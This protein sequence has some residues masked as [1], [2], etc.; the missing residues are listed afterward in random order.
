MG[1][2]AI[3]DLTFAGVSATAKLVLEAD[4]IIL[5]G[6]VRARIARTAIHDYGVEGDDLVVATDQCELRARL[7]AKQANL[8][9]KAIAKP[10]PSLA[11]NLGISDGVPTLVIGR[12]TDAALIAAVGMAAENLGDTSRAVQILTEIS[13]DTHLAATMAA[14]RSNP[15]AALWCITVKGPA[16]PLSEAK[17]R[18][19]LR[20]LGYIDTKS[21][22]VSHRMTATRYSKRRP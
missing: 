9:A 1:R 13:D 5:R 11:Q 12:L 18:Q 20:D 22:A 14:A 8:W 3:A 4:E 7:G 19:A 17:L 16:A 6:A 2:E 15:L 10:A 21:C